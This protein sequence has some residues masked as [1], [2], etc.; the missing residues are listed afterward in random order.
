MIR[1]ILSINIR[2]FFC[3]LTFS[4]AV[5]QVLRYVAQLVAFNLIRFVRQSYN[6]KKLSTSSP[7]KFS[8]FDRGYFIQ[9]IR[10]TLALSAAMLEK[11]HCNVLYY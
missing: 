5:D 7:R 10:F 1:L 3:F 8:S 6:S 2:S 4:K 11:K 9:K